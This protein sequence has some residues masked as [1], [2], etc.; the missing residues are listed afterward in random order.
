ML[1]HVRPG[2]L[3]G[4]LEMLPEDGSRI[5][6]YKL[7]DELG[8]EVDAILPIVE[9]GVLLG[10]VSLAEGDVQMTDAGR[11]FA[12]ADILKQKE[13]FRDAGLKSVPLLNQIHKAVAAKPDHRVADEFFR[14]LLDEY[15]TEEELQRQLETVIAWGR[16]AELFD[17]DAAQKRFFLPEPEPEPV[18]GAAGVSE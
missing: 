2:G 8:L 9:A 13:L 12:E 17:Y 15:F 18:P 5:D 14:D 3:A 11:Q 1:P 10:F 6:M 4:L 16:Y 7:A